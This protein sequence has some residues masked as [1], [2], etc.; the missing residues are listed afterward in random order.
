MIYRKFFFKE[1]KSPEI[2]M[3]VYFNPSQSVGLEAILNE[4]DNRHLTDTRWLAYMLATVYHETARTMRPVEEIGKGKK[5]KYGQKDKE[6]GHVYYGRGFV[7]LTW[8]DNYFKFER[9]LGVPLVKQPE[10]ALDLEISTRILFDGMIKGLFTGKKLSDYF[11]GE[12][13][14]D[15]YSA[16]KIIN[17]LD[18][19]G[20][21]GIYA[22]KF[23]KSIAKI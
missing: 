8:K 1:L 20:E 4:W 21:I 14:C 10:L 23:F 3:F 12:Q 16:R 2:N 18:K 15:W 11:N 7:Q 22:Q 17:G 9:E 19:A 5:Y 6:T 13:I